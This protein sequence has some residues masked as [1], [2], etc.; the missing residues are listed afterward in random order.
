MPAENQHSVF[1]YGECEI[2]LDRREFRA[3]GVPVPLGSRAF[4]LIENLARAAG[5]IVSKD[6][7]MHRVW[8]GSIVEE[9]TLQVHIS[10]VRKALG[11]YRAMLKTESGRGYRLLGGW[12][13]HEATDVV[14][15]ARPPPA[16][17]RTEPVRANLPAAA[18]TLIGRSEAVQRLSDLLSAYRAVTLTGPGGIGKTTLALEV[19]RNSVSRFDDGAC[20]VELAPLSDR[21]L[22]P[23]SLAGALGLSLAG[24]AISAE[25]VARGV[26]GRHVL[27]ILDNC[28]HLIEAAAEMAETIVRLCPRATVL[29][30]SRETLRI[31]GE[32]VYRVPP[33][34]VPDLVQTE[35]YDLL[36]HSAI[37]LFVAKTKVL[38]SSFAPEGGSL[39]SVASICRHLDGIP[40]AIEFAAARAA[41][42]GVDYV[43]KGLADRFTL[44]TGGRRNALPRQQ[45][46]RAALDW[47]YDLLTEAEQRLLRYLAIFAGSFTYEA[48]SAVIRDIALPA[49]SLGETIANLVTKSLV[50]FDG[51]ATVSRW[52]LLETVRAYAIQKLAE[53]GELEAAA[54]C[55][56]EYHSDLFGRA[57]SDW[58]S[59]PSAAW[60]AEY[61][62]RL[63]DLRATLDWAFSPTGDAALGLD[64]TVDAVPLWMQF[65]LMA[66]ARG[67]V[68]QA[69][70]RIEQETTENIRLRMRLWTALGLSRMYTGEPLSDVEAA[71]HASLQLAEQL[72]D[73]D[74][75]RRAIWGL[76]AGAFNGGAFR[77]ALELAERFCSVAS[78]PSDKLV[79]ERLIGTA[80]HFLGDQKAAR[81][82]IEHM[83]AGYIAPATSSHL[84]RYQ[85]EQVI[86]ARRVLAP[87]L[88][89][90]GYP[91][92][93]MTM[94][95][96]AVADA[97]HLDHALTLCNFLA[98]AGC[99]VAF[100]VGDLDAARRF[101]AILL[102][103]AI[104]HSLDV[105]VAH[106]RLFEGSLLIAGGS[107]EEGLQRMRQG[108]NAL[109]DAAFFQSYTPYLSALAEGL[110][111]A[112]NTTSA[113][114]AIDEALTRA[115]STEERWCL[116]ELL[117]VKGELNHQNG[118]KARAETYFEKALTVAR[119]QEVLSWELRAA[120]NF[121]RL[122]SAQGRRDEARS[123]LAPVYE[124]FT[125]GFGTADLRTA[126]ALLDS[127]APDARG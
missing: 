114:A 105:W 58:E 124:R 29:A 113:L 63:D 15:P 104:R 61:G 73:L 106:G 90:Q 76:F 110:R 96:A 101:T 48:A 107:F 88:W 12:T 112:G 77:T 51:S 66:E 118:D 34:D 28:E 94:V 55:H 44:L 62:H 42:L 32:C 115:E 19:A 45:T 6:E 50:T 123:I 59:Q 102:E 41:T 16:Y 65:S 20:F 89:L 52:R 31:E 92:K 7:L 35:P 86:A 11:P 36:S 23:S 116:A 27:L 9:N 37:E 120:S 17:P 56:A 24:D 10:A 127:W 33:L 125:E 47:S 26:A 83:L 46:L 25:A 69:L 54:R 5:D 108:G 38:D 39:A 78:D 79:G 18:G 93:A 71:W 97:L 43:A 122:R 22:L 111:A 57:R 49:E 72:G 14:A 103:Y 91:D 117:R 64:L 84:I 13:L 21:A 121:A 2:D 81:Q 30:T 67:R 3:R 4:D 87:I 85:N 100:L 75:Q 95:E 8:P 80:L 74:Y 40:L 1:Q 82:H 126:K 109:R 98:Q 68:E 60:L 70:S 99:P 53:R 119:E